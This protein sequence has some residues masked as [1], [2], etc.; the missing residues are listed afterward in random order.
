MR[1]AFVL[2]TLFLNPKEAL[3]DETYYAISRLCCHVLNDPL[4]QQYV[5]F[6]V[7]TQDALMI[8]NWLWGAEAERL[9]SIAMDEIPFSPR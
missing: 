1:N 6:D 9:R 5:S 3:G 8:S 7:A 2:D 4:D